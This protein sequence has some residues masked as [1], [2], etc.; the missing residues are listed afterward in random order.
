M[1]YGYYIQPRWGWLYL[2][3]HS[4]G[5]THGYSYLSPSGLIN[6]KHNDEE[7]RWYKLQQMAILRLRPGPADLIKNRKVFFNKH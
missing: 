2:L 3:F 4:M 7:C 5:S 6:R 1:C